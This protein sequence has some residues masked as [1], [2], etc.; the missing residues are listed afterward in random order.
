MWNFYFGPARDIEREREREREEQ[1]MVGAAPGDKKSQRL[2]TEE[3][4]QK[5]EEKANTKLVAFII[6]RSGRIFYFARF[7]KQL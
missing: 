4:F 1:H 2:K 3:I 6:L 5:F 7:K